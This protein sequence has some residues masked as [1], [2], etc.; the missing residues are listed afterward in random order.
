[1]SKCCLLE[2]MCFFWS[3]KAKITYVLLLFN[4]VF[5]LAVSVHY[6]C[7]LTMWHQFEIIEA[8]YHMLYMYI[9]AFYSHTTIMQNFDVKVD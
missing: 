8:N 7:F 2:T 4:S 6:S 9:A 5:Y 3:E 1:M